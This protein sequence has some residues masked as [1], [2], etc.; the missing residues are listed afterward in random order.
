VVS[1]ANSALALN[2]IVGTQLMQVVGAAVCNDPTGCPSNTVD[3]TSI[4]NFEASD[5]PAKF[6]NYTYLV[7]GINVLGLILFTQFL[8]RQKEE[9]NEW[10]IKGEMSGHNRLIGYAS[11]LV[12][13]VSI[14]Y[15]I[16]ASI[17]LV[18]EKTS[19]L[20]VFGG[21]GC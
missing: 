19:C 12:A 14:T 20:Q 7:L 17:M 13:T 5:G 16:L 21:S 6:A 9:C 10:R 15:G 8:P 1:V 2:T 4:A 3:V 11:I 18:N